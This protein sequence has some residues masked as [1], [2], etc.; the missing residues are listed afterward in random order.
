[1]SDNKHFNYPARMEDARFI[2]DYRTPTRRN[3]SIKYMNRI[4]RDDQYRL[5]LQTQGK[6]MMNATWDD[7]KKHDDVWVNVCIH[8]YPTRCTMKEMVAERA[9]FDTIFPLDRLNKGPTNCVPRK[10]YRMCPS[11]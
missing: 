4:Y 11:M 9:D 5:F 6:A 1:M 7:H 2:T 10:D 8:N 3:E